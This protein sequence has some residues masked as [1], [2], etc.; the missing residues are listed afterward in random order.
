M[1]ECKFVEQLHSSILDSRINN[2]NRYS[3]KFI[4]LALI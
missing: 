3:L 2:S 4:N 1:A